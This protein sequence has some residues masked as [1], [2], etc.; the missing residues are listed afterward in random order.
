MFDLVA[1]LQQAK[2]GPWRY[3]V[4]ATCADENIVRNFLHWMRYEHGADLLKI[5]GCTEFRSF[6]ISPLEVHCEY[7]FSTRSALD[8]YLV[9]AAN[10]LRAK[11]RELFS[12]AD[13]SFRRDETRLICQG[14]TRKKRD[15]V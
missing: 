15:F 11:G 6:Q 10:E 14:V 8:R 5:T 1:R 4:M 12:E 3:R 7:I 9:G 13:V 2:E